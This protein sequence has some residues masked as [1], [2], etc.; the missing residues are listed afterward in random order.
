MLHSHHNT[1]HIT[2]LSHGSISQLAPSFVDLPILHMQMVSTV[3]A[4]TQ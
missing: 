2:K 3:C 1:L 4:V